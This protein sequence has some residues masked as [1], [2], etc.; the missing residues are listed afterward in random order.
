[1]TSSQEQPQHAIADAQAPEAVLQRWVLSHAGASSS[2]T[3]AAFGASRLRGCAAAGDLAAG[4]VVLQVPVQ[5]LITNDT[6]AAS[7]FGKALSR[8]PGGWC[9]LRRGPACAAPHTRVW[10]L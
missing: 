3:P 7:D 9:A 2:I 1:L 6:A 5:L 4:S 10:L 8:L